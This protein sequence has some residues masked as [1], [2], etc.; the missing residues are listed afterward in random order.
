[1]AKDVNK[2]PKKSL[3]ARGIETIKERYGW[4]CVSPWVVGLII[5]FIIPIFQSFIYTFCRV[6]LVAGGLKTEWVGLENLVYIFT[7]DT[8]FKDNL[9]V[10]VGSFAY[11]FPIILVLSLVLAL[12]LNQKFKGRIVFRAI[13]FLPVIIASG[14]I[15][16]TIIGDKSISAA[17][18]DQAVA[19][20]MIDVSEI[21][22]WTG[23]P[24]KIADYFNSAISEIMNLIWKCGVQIILFIAGM[25]SIPD[26]YY[27][28]SKVEGATAW[29]EF[30][31]I[32]F[33]SLSRVITLVTVFTMVELMTSQNDKVISQAYNFIESMSYGQSSAMLWV[34]FCI[35]G[36][37]LGTILFAFNRFCAKKWE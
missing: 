1:M 7:R 2:K 31:F 5:F 32:T 4:I 29:E 11:S 35:I 33:P 17:D 21:I 20:N 30:W 37:I 9:G 15:L 28:V 34:Y 8:K 22:K 16:G 10:S 19:E 25:Q 18:A 14:A 23:L 12:L 6:S 26:L 24:D 3:H 27:E 36:A 13:Y